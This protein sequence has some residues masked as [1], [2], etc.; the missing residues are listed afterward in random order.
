MWS[1][2]HSD[3]HVTLFIGLQLL[4]PSDLFDNPT[5]NQHFLIIPSRV[6]PKVRDLIKFPYFVD[7]IERGDWGEG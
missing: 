7:T 4:Q 3:N 5:Q 2:Q 1:V 6:I